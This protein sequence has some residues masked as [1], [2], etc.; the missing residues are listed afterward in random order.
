MSERELDLLLADGRG[1]RSS[2]AA[3]PRR[4]CASPTR[5]AR[6]AQVVAM[7]GDGVNDAP[8]LR[9]ADI[10]V[11]MGLTGTDVAREAATMV[12]TDDNFATIVARGRGG[13]PG[14]RQRP[15]VHRLH[16][17]PR[18]ARGRPVPRLRALRRRDPAAADRAPDPRDRP[19]H[20][21]PARARARPRAGRARPHGPAAAAAARGRD[22]PRDARARLGLPRPDRGGA[23]PRRVLLRPARGRLGTRATTSPP[24]R[25]LHD[26][27][28][29]RRR[30]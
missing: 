4:S 22:P 1:A 30:R 8:A 2:R 15:Q 7:T 17:R 6:T 10:G 11:A 27:V 29:R 5:C 9:R 23:R 3:R 25:P 26:A 16:L 21:D 14:L 13:P 20:R 24:G 18:D 19:R 12:L 28:P